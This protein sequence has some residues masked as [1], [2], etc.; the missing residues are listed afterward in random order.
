MLIIILVL[1]FAGGEGY[2][3]HR[4]WGPGGGIG[5]V[6]AVLDIWSGIAELGVSESFICTS[7]RLRCARKLTFPL[8]GS[9]LNYENGFL[10][11]RC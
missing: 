2:Y 1:L 6:G 11:R 8:S 3:G 7:R 4:T 10:F 5:I 9:H